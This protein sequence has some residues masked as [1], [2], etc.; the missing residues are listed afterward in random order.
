[1]AELAPVNNSKALSNSAKCC[2]GAVEGAPEVFMGGER[3]SVQ[4]R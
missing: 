1:M 3:A 2:D 4:S